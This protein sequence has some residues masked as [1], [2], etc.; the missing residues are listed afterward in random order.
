MTR[1]TSHERFKY[2]RNIRIRQQFA[3][4]IH[5]CISFYPSMLFYLFLRMRIHAHFKRALECY[6][7]R[8]IRN[9]LLDFLA[10][11]FASSF[12]LSELWKRKMEKTGW[13]LMSFPVLYTYVC[14][15]M[16]IISLMGLSASLLCLSK[17]QKYGY[18][19]N[20]LISFRQFQ[21]TILIFLYFHNCYVE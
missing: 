6:M 1:T 10:K 21:R 7:S 12:F 19:L 2:S 3:S 16:I 11:D 4:G 9:I 8:M 15:L 13:I 18:K 5:G 17:T 14:R 20:M